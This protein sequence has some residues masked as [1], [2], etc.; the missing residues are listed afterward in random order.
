ELK[1]KEKVSL[2]WLW[3]PILSGSIFVALSLYT[4]IEIA[5]ILLGV[6]AVMGVVALCSGHTSWYRSICLSA[7][8]GFLLFTPWFVTV[9]LL[10]FPEQLVL[11]SGVY[12]ALILLTA[13]LSFIPGMKGNEKKIETVLLALVLGLF[14]WV[15]ALG[16]FESVFRLSGY[17]VYAAAASA[18]LF[19]FLAFKNPNLTRDSWF[20][21]IWIFALGFI[22]LMPY[23]HPLATALGVPESLNY[24]L[25]DKELGSVFPETRAKIHEYFL[26]F[27]GVT[28][29]ALS[30][31]FFRRFWVWPRWIYQGVVIVIV[32][33]LAVR[34]HESD[35][36]PYPKGQTLT[37]NVDLM[38]VSSLVFEKTPPWFN[39]S[40]QEVLSVLDEEAEATD[41]VFNMYTVYNPYSPEFLAHYIVYGISTTPLEEDEIVSSEY[42]TE[43][44]DQV[45][46]A[47]TE[48]VVIVVDF[49]SVETWLNDPRLEIL[50]SSQDTAYVLLKVKD[51]SST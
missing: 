27:F 34:L 26:P 3:R 25:F 33:V 15:T 31:A 8:G 7:A 13:G 44:L 14:V 6:M 49:H 46:A 48:F 21:S 39:E 47:G 20:L 36:L 50:A 19:Y 35:F 28:L 4:N 40:Y 2:K 30:L 17:L 5:A 29:V 12:V 1:G 23:F 22:A 32:F 9:A 16:Q 45:I 43:L 11:M 18:V 41:D 10:V 42:T 37:A 51:Q 24:F 38:L